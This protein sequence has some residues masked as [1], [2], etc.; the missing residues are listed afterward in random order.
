[1]TTS[2]AEGPKSGQ[3][4]RFQRS[5][6]VCKN[7]KVCAGRMLHVLPVLLMILFLFQG[8]A[9]ARSRTYSQNQWVR[10][11][12]TA[13][14][15]SGETASQTITEE[16]RTLAADPTVLPIGTVVEVRHAGPYSG[17]YVVQDTGQKIVG[18]KLDI[19]IA[20]TREALQFG[21]RRVTVRVLK[22]APLT[23]H[24][25]RKAAAEASIDPKPPKAE[26]VSDYYQYSADA[27]GSDSVE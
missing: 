27:R 14:S 22:P 6:L 23:P 10:F 7:L 4:I 21:K 13:Y 24:E 3:N 16:G 20:R 2:K 19:Y 15:V 18:R 12:A 17:Q 5:N 8:H 9:Y 11:V 1:M 25:Q 26:R